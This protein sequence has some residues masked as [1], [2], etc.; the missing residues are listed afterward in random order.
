M[1]DIFGA[2]LVSVG[3]VPRKIVTYKKNADEYV[4]A[5]EPFIEPGLKIVCAVDDLSVAGVYTFSLQ[6]QH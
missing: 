1:H 2:P 3:S 4:E 6:S 5:L